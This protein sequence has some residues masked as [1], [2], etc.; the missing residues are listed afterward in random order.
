M[1]SYDN[2]FR[3]LRLACLDIMCCAAF[4]MSKEDVSAFCVSSPSSQSAGMPSLLLSMSSNSGSQSSSCDGASSNMKPKYAA[5]RDIRTVQGHQEAR[6][7][8]WTLLDEN[9]G[10]LTAGTRIAVSPDTPQR[11]DE[12][13]GGNYCPEEEG[14]SWAGLLD[15]RERIRRLRT[16]FIEHKYQHQHVALLIGVRQEDQGL[17]C[18][19]PLFL[20]PVAPGSVSL[21][22]YPLSAPSKGSDNQN[23]S[24][25]S[26]LIALF[27]LGLAVPRVWLAE[28]LGEEN[29]ALMQRY[30]LLYPCSVD[31]TLLVPYVHIFPVDFSTRDE[32]SCMWFVTDLHPLVLSTTSVGTRPDQKE[33]NTVMYIGPDSLALAQHFSPYYHLVDKFA[34]KPVYG[35][36]LG[37]G[38]GIQALSALMHW[39]NSATTLGTQPAKLKMVAVD[40]NHRAL[41]F[42]LFNSI[43]N[44]LEE[45]ISFRQA[46]ILKSESYVVDIENNNFRGFHLILSNPPFLPVPSCDL[47]SY[48]LGSIANDNEF[49]VRR[50]ISKRYGLFSSG[51]ESG[52]AILER[53]IEIASEKLAVG[54]VLGVVSEFFTQRHDPEFT[55]FSSWWRKP[56]DCQSA[57]GIL[58]QNE[59]PIDAQTYARRRADNDKERHVWLRHLELLNVS[60]AS[61][62]LMYIRKNENVH[63]IDTDSGL[64]LTSHRVPKTEL[65]SIWTPANVYAIRFTQEI[66]R[67]IFGWF[68][69]G[70]SRTTATK[71]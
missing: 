38:S 18:T 70:S 49:A 23:L 5:A 60:A 26:Y 39:T 34:D 22:N 50:V 71:K 53:I 24:G 55:R 2:W 57:T 19:G 36:D 56:R 37:T 48:E 43:L 30:G 68:K 21:D 25:L 17:A 13:C 66:S 28:A 11:H 45:D 29:C 14:N 63:D 3:K 35:L 7:L 67:Q 44:G 47:S 1:A 58:F 8:Y 33:G 40:V 6:H 64:N 27:L 51:G 52:E 69:N 10:D 59:Y 46:D 42:A 20:S 62:G 9:P 4:L 54:G 16:L 41:R 65:G 15:E 32:R 61:P 12:A 31:K